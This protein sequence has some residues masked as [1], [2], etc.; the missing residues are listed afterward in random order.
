[1]AIIDIKSKVASVNSTD[2]PLDTTSV[3]LIAVETKF[4]TTSCK[5]N[6]LA[7]FEM[8]EDPA[9]PAEIH[10][11]NKDKA[12]VIRFW[13]LDGTCCGLLLNWVT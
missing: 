2:V 11:V 9:L 8:K 12:T 1:M 4:F 3:Q 13:V 7:T 6:D 10:R 5:A